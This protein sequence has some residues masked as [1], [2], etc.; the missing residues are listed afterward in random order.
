MPTPAELAK[1]ARSR[2]EV[3]HYRA[4]AEQRQTKALTKPEPEFTEEH[5]RKMLAN[6]RALSASLATQH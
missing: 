3:A 4:L 6:F 1:E 2:A 5:R